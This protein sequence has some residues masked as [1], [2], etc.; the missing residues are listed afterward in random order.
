MMGLYRRGM[1]TEGE[2]RRFERS[3][4]CSGDTPHARRSRRLNNRSS[5]EGDDWVSLYAIA[6]NE[7]NAAGSGLSSPLHQRCSRHHSA[8]LRYYRIIAQ[9]RTSKVNVA[10]C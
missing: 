4:P 10:S 7:E 2:L 3:S 8:T 1:V 9:G 5:H 6:V